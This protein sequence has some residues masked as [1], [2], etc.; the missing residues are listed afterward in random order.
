M[1][2]FG[3]KSQKIAKRW[4]LRPQTPVQLK[5]LDNVQDSTLIEI[6][7]WCS[8]LAIWEQN[9]TLYFIY[10]ALILLKKR[11]HAAR[12]M[13][14]RASERYRPWGTSTHFTQPFKN[15]FLR[16][17]LDQNTPKIVC[18]FGKKLYNRHSIGDS[19]PE[20]P[21][22]SDG[23]RLRPPDSRVVSPAYWYSFV[24]EVWL[25]IVLYFAWQQRL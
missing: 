2:Y 25:E 18:F 11:S 24:E 21:F 8:C 19:V 14:A 3:S 9:E 1:D 4:E 13:E 15:V 6:T 22:T 23:W 7:G 16:I 5:W 10:F 17:N 12:Q 20:F